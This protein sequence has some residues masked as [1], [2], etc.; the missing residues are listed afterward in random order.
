MS[1][2]VDKITIRSISYNKYKMQ[3]LPRQSETCL[4][5]LGFKQ[6]NVIG[7]YSA[8]VTIFIQTVVFFI[9]L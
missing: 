7:R 9:I 4:L 8:V 2:Q 6:L 1:L 5:S 3:Q